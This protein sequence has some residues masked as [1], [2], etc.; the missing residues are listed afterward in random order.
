M[1]VE[2]VQWGA[3]K[4]NNETSNERASVGARGGE[5]SLAD[6]KRANGELGSF[7]QEGG[8]RGSTP[9]RRHQGD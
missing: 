1:E 3:Q 6:N 5:T 9:A 2:P 8:L 4:K 7:A